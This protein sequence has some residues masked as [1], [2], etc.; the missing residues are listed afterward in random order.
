MA[1]DAGSRRSRQLRGPVEQRRGRVHRNL[2]SGLTQPLQAGQGVARALGGIAACIGST[3]SAAFGSAFSAAGSRLCSARRNAPS[4]PAGARRASAGERSER[5]RRRAAS[6]RPRTATGPRLGPHC[7]RAGRE[8]SCPGAAAPGCNR[9]QRRQRGQPGELAADAGKCHRP[10]REAEHQVLAAGTG[11]QEGGVVPALGERLDG[12]VGHRRELTDQPACER[13][14]DF[15]FRCPGR[16]R[17]E[18]HPPHQR[19]RAKI[20]CSAAAQTSRSS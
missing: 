12:R 16:G 3:S 4:S 2:E 15:T 11:R 6:T 1:D 8:P 20:A 17:H 18:T 7:R 10:A 5:V 14:A 19:T 13:K 9:Q